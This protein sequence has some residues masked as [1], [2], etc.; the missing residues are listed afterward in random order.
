M[1]ARRRGAQPNNTNA[2]KHGF[3][4]RQFRQVDLEDLQ[5]VSSGLTDEITAL[6]VLL[7]RVLEV[8]EQQESD[9]ET[10][11]GLLKAASTG[12]RTLGS[13]LRTEQILTGSHSDMQSILSQALAE[14][15]KD[16]HL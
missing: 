11:L 1:T 7:R 14:I 5:A 9:P 4:S 3:Y 16:I 13:L 2:L 15:N 10:W 6:R 8:I 12:F